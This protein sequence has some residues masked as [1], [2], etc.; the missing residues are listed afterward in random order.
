MKSR[1][2]MLL[3]VVCVAAWLGQGVATGADP[4]SVASQPATG[5]GC[6]R[7]DVTAGPPEKLSAAEE[8]IKQC[9]NPVPWLT[10]GADLRLREHLEENLR[11]N[12][13]VIDHE[14]HYQRYRARLW[15][16]FTPFA[17]LPDLS[18]NTRLVWEFFN[19]CR[20]AGVEGTALE[21]IRDTNFDEVLFDTLNV[22]YKN[23]FGLPTTITVGRQDIIYGDGWLVLD[24][25]PMD[26][27]RTIYFDA[28]RTQTEL[29]PIQSTVDV[30]YINQHAREDWWIEPFGYRNNRAVTEQDEQGAIVWFANKSIAKTEIDGYFIYKHEEIDPTATLVSV[31]DEG[32]IYTF[33]ARG[34]SDFTDNWQAKA[35][36]AGQFGKTS[37]GAG[38]E[39]RQLCALGANTKLTY[40][41]RDQWNN[42]FR[43]AYE[44]LSGDDPNT[45]TNEAFDSL[46]GRWPQWSELY[47]T[48]IALETGRPAL[49]TNMNRVA[50]GWTT[51]PVKNWEYCLD[52]H[53]LFADQNTFPTSANFSENGLFRGQLI[54]SVLKYKFTDHISGHFWAELF[55][56]GNYYS[57]F[58]ND[59]ALFLRYELV[60]SF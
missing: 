14:R 20:P 34:V 7:I 13:D 3:A 60:F 41:L 22:K 27:S 28:V 49:M 55:A 26:G 10:W 21:G 2:I 33:G 25:T 57:D 48:T 50:V 16:N 17:E 1:W 44:H 18:I 46:W 24:G 40:F 38:A 39:S 35:E 30:V 51:T 56:P 54:T 53:L 45:K 47:V 4:V 19:F 8:W 6:D 52:Y 32:D 23:A 11:L 42:Q 9:K 12:E 36:I 37:H 15:A 31:P 5:P 29:K 59:V 43:L 58:R